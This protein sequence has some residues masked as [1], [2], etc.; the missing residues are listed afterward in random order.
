MNKKQLQKKLFELQVKKSC[1]TYKMK[2]H[3]LKKDASYL[4]MCN[5][6][7]ALHCQIQEI[8]LQL[9]T[10]DSVYREIYES[11]VKLSSGWKS[12]IEKHKLNNLI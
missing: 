8:A 1:A 4:K 11:S 6:F 2:S 7:I 3:P 10:C 9:I 5:F 12:V